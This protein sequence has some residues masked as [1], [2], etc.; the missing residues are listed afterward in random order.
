VAQRVP[1]THI[2]VVANTF[3]IRK[4]DPESTDFMFSKNLWSVAEEKG[5]WSPKDGLL[6]FLATYSPPRYHPDYSNRRYVL[7][8]R[9]SNA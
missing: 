7:M 9:R 8:L 6:D 3:V 4:V 2:T 5:W 1:D